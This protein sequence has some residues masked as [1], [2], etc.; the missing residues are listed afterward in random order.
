MALPN[1]ISKLVN[2][3]RLQAQGNL[4]EALPRGIGALTNLTTLMLGSQAP[5][6]RG[7]NALSTLPSEFSNLQALTK[8]RLDQN[9]FVH[10]PIV[11]TTLTNLQELYMARNRL[12]TITR[13][14]G[15]MVS[16]RLINLSK[17]ILTSLPNVFDDLS[18]VR[19][20]FFFFC[21]AEGGIGRLEGCDT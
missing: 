19:L 2:L 5:D 11:L 9:A 12:A 13:G 1:E 10:F 3:E 18:Q 14:L 16:L 20:F 21:C 15:A 17:N 6:D 7:R 8:L 4:I